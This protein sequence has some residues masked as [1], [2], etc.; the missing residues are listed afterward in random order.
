[1]AGIQEE[2]SNALKFAKQAEGWEVQ[3]TAAAKQI[4]MIVE[5]AKQARELAEEMRK[6]HMKQRRKLSLQ[7]LHLNRRMRQPKEQQMLQSKH[8]RVKTGRTN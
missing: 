6:K 2:A 5:A 8:Q 7:K 3:A 4:C 1:M